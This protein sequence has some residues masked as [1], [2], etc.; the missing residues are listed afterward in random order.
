MQI[1]LQPGELLRE[2]TD[3]AVLISFE[4]APLPA[5]VAELLEP[6][7][8]RGKSKQTLLVYG[9]DTVAPRRVLLVG[10]GKQEK[11]S[12]EGLRQAGALAVQ[13]ARSMQLRAFTLGLNGELPLAPELA[14]QALAEGIELGAYRYDR[15]RTGLSD[16]QRFTVEHATIV[17]DSAEQPMRAGIAS[18][19]AIARGVMFARDLVNAPGGVLTPAAFGDEAVSLGKRA[20]L[21]V[22]VLDKAQ[23]NEQG[24]GGVL[25][26]GQGS[27]NEPRF[28]V[29]EYGT[30]GA[31]TPTI[32]LV[33]KGLTFDSGGLS[34]KPAEFMSTMKS[35]MGGGAAVFGAMQA[36][37]ELKLPLHVV[38]IVPAAENM[39][40]ATAF[41]PDD[42]I[43]S[44]SGK[45]IE[46][47]NTDAEGRIILA[48]GLF[49]A[50]RYKPDA[51]VELS[52]LTGAII[53]ALGSH[54]IGMMSTSQELADKISHAGEASGERVWQLPLWDEYHE[55]IKSQIADLKNI[56]G[57]AAGSIT[58]GAFLANFVG[59]YPFVHLDI[60]GTAYAEKPAKP[61]GSPGG[62]G[63]GVRLIAEY[64]QTLA[65]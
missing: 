60:A 46:V 33:G 22:V 45:T 25:A 42:V 37:A 49:Y 7:D 15:Y 14:A 63:V 6:A 23:L 19:Q 8:F 31:G 50:Q 61:Y 36:V 5:G 16:E 41:R 11:A 54:A 44:L 48:D 20:G 26:V 32:C 21:N 64:L 29:M 10:L 9:R 17:A 2:A 51:I 1:T 62:T 65:K 30:A 4:D 53:I 38:G 28:I 52:T 12:A 24:F 27:A 47:L 57:R 35:D 18:G 39:P 56:G 13:Q 59:D 3:L 58:A 55:M 43:T 34:L 40:S